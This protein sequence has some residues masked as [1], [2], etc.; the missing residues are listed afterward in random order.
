VESLK[1]NDL[2]A[3]SDLFVFCDGAKDAQD[4]PKVT[5][6]RDYLRT[7]TGFRSV[8]I[9]ERK[10]NAGLA[11]SVIDGATKL[12]EERGRLIAVEDDLLTA[13]DF[14]TFMNQALSRY[15]KE[16]RIFSVSGFNF[17]LDAAPGHSWDAFTFYRS[18]SL[19][20]G[21]WRDRWEK[22]D[23]TVAD[24]AEF[25]GDKAKHKTF[26]RGG[27][28]LSRMLRLQMEGWIDS[29]AIRWAYEHCRHDAL[30]LHSLRSRVFHIGAD[31][32]GTNARQGSLKQTPLTTEQSTE[33]RFPDEI[34]VEAQFAQQLQ[35]QFKASTARRVARYL[36]QALRVWHGMSAERLMAAAIGSRPRSKRIGQIP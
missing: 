20:W 35:K 33:F 6:V 10:G 34:A 9:V 26:N 23:W 1:A 32:T 8:N 19:G 12:C 24:Y 31:G 36:R 22:A 29:W 4:Q 27:E 17:A 5:S 14:L 3:F 11:K 13:P 30:A 2:A 25:C 16:S 21:T 18:S 15:E 28:D 7:I